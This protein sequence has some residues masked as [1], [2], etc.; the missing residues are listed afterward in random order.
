MRF[1]VT[2]TPLSS[3]AMAFFGNPTFPVVQPI[4]QFRSVEMRDTYCNILPDVSRKAAR[5]DGES[6]RSAERRS[7]RELNPGSR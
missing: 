1:S 4:Y 3:V 2:T 6:Q 5:T 7:R